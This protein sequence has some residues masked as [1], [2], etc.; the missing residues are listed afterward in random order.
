[1][2]RS[3]MLMIKYLTNITNLVTNTRLNAK[4]NEVKGI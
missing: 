3:K 2:L 1:M 4:I